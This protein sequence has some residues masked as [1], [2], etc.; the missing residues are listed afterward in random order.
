VMLA[1]GVA[2]PTEARPAELNNSDWAP[3]KSKK[4]P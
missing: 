3:P 4:L 1:A 2:P